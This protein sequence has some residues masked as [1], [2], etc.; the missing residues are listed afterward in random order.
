M[1]RAADPEGSTSSCI[2]VNPHTLSRMKIPPHAGRISEK[3]MIHFPVPE[4]L[5]FDDVLL[6]PARSDVIPATATTQ[7]LASA[8]A[9]LMNYPLSPISATVSGTVIS[10]RSTLN[11]AAT[12]YSL[13]TSYNYDTTDFSSPAFTAAA[14]G[15]QLT[16]GTD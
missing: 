6:L 4:A 1:L 11:G 16:G 9:G 5:T 14:S 2:C 15:T 13:S 10:I 3:L 8:L 7:T 12:N